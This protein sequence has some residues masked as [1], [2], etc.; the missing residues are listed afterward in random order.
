MPV[1]LSCLS[2][3]RSM[4][5]DSGIASAPQQEVEVLTPFELPWLPLFLR[6][7]NTS[8]S[9][10]ASQKASFC[11]LFLLFHQNCIQLINTGP[12]FC[13]QHLTVLCDGLCDLGPSHRHAGTA[14]T[15]LQASAVCPSDISSTGPSISSSR[16]TGRTGEALTTVRSFSTWHV[17]QNPVSA[18][19]SDASHATC[20]ID[21]AT[22]VFLFLEMPSSFPLKAFALPCA[23]NFFPLHPH[24]PLNMTSFKEKL[25]CH[26]LSDISLIIP[27][28]RG[29]SVLCSPGG[30]TYLC[31][32]V[33]CPHENFNLSS[34]RGTVKFRGCAGQGLPYRPFGE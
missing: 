15:V 5:Q 12:S 20:H 14:L 3:V 28:K 17:E 11:F 21:S 34:A 22:P 24:H 7:G 27:L 19:V 32:A 16:N 25:K 9:V 23:Q 30:G 10:Q 26:F 31:I 13:L 8:T 18:Q 33:Y 6:R 4:V 1:S 29:F 2:P